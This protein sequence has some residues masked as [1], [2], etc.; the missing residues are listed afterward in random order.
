MPK[1]RIPL[2]E[3]LGLKF[4][5]DTTAEKHN[6]K[7]YADFAREMDKQPR[8]KDIDINED[9]RVTGHTI[10][11]WREIFDKEKDKG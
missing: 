11:N 10:G 2:I 3:L 1:P 7:K 9:F 6:G 5:L 4:Y 8:P